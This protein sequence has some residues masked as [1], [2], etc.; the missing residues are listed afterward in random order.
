MFNIDKTLQ[1]TL[2]ARRRMASG[3]CTRLGIHQG[4]SLS[5]LIG[6]GTECTNEAAVATWLADRDIDATQKGFETACRSLEQTLR[7]LEDGE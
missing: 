7:D 2:A 1:P 6:D 5:F 4:S 3:I